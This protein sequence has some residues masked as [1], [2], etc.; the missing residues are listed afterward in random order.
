VSRRTVG[1]GLL[2]SVA[3]L[4]NVVVV[5]TAFGIRGALPIATVM[6]CAALALVMVHLDWRALLPLVWRPVEHV[7]SAR[8]SGRGR[9]LWLVTLVLVLGYPLYINIATR[10]G[11]GGQVPP[12]GRW[13][14]LECG[15]ASRL[16]L[17][18][19]QAGRGAAVLY[20]EVGQWGQ[21]VTESERRNASFTYD[22]ARGF[23]EV[24]IASSSSTGEP[25][26][27]LGG[28]VY[29]GDTIVTL[30]GRAVGVLPFQVRLQRTR[31]AP[32]PPVRAF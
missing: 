24:R 10:R 9:M 5:D 22:K 27:V 17:C 19:S 16:A 18:R 29:E 4:T 28:T 26:L 20:S 1:A 13:E 30:E 11:L 32:W 7:R 31:S 21:L 12:A 14:V 25:E 15:S 23:L 8:H 3:A 2:L 6:A